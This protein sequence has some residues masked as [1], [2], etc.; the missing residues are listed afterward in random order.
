M[1]KETPTEQRWFKILVLTLGVI[2]IIASLINIYYI[3]KNRKV[4][5]DDESS[6][7]LNVALWSSVAIL[8]IGLVLTG[9]GVYAL[10][11]SKEQQSKFNKFLTSNEPLRIPPSPQQYQQYQQGQRIQ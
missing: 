10:F 6:F 1:E 3:W 11:T 4:H 9:F 7:E 8:V 2:I 5:Q